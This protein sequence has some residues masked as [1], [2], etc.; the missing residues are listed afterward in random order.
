MKVARVQAMAARIM[1]REKNE[2]PRLVSLTKNF[3]G[4]VSLIAFRDLKRKQCGQCVYHLV[5]VER[6][7]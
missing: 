3:G 5:Q 2:R 1:S 6:N 4:I 7:Y